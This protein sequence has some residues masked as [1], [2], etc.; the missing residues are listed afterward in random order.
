MTDPIIDDIL[1]QGANSTFQQHTTTARHFITD[2]NAARYNFRTRYQRKPI[3]KQQQKSE[4]VKTLLKHTP[5]DPLSI[6]L[7][8]R[9]KRGV[10]GGNRARATVD[11]VANRFPMDVTVGKVTYHYWFNQ[12]PNTEVTHRNARLHRVL[13]LGAQERY[14]EAPINLNIRSGLTDAEEIEWYINMNKNQKAHSKGTLLNA[15]ICQ[16]PD[17]P[18]VIALLDV[19]SHVKDRFQIPTNELD[20]N[21]LGSQL[22][23][24]SG[25]SVDTTDERDEKEDN[26]LTAANLLNLLANGQTYKDGFRGQINR[27]VL[28]QNINLVLEIIGD[29]EPSAQMIDEFTSSSTSKKPFQPKFWS[30]AYLLGPM[31]WSVAHKKENVVAIWR[32]FLRVCNVNMINTIYLQEVN[33][34]HDGDDV[35]AKYELAWNRLVAFMQNRALGTA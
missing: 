27:D 14:L 30:C 33:D 20:E 25:C 17:D 12:V 7:R 24:I 16:Y 4:W 13:P 28:E 1:A 15:Y 18:W 19:F 29:Y 10:N 3:W 2:F 26:V 5:V 8:G 9:E 21:S 22:E 35:V 11:Y 34:R 6:S 32:D 23:N 31:F